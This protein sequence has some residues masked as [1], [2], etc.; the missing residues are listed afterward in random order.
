MSQDKPSQAKAKPKAVF[1]LVMPLFLLRFS[2][3]TPKLPIGPIQPTSNLIGPK[4]SQAN[5]KQVPVNQSES[6]SES[7]IYDQI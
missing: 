2:L 1:D 6:E 5:F 7:E 4:S 3:F